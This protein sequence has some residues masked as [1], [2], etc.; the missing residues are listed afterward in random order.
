MGM[1]HYFGTIQIFKCKHTVS[2]GEMQ[3]F[4]VEMESFLRKCKCLVEEHILGADAKFVGKRNT[5]SSKRN[6]S[7]GSITFL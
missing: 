2:C 1:R 4:S 6:I 5:F 7:L 3:S